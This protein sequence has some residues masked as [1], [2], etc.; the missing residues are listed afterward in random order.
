MLQDYLFRMPDLSGYKDAERI[1]PTAMILLMRLYFLSDKGTH[2]CYFSLSWGA[3]HSMGSRASLTRASTLLVDLGIVTCEEAPG[4]VNVYSFSAEF[5]K[6]IQTGNDDLNQNDEGTCLKMRRVAPQEGQNNLPQNDEGTCLKMRRGVA[7][8]EEGGCSKCGTI[9]RNEED[10]KGSQYRHAGRIRVN[11]KIDGEQIIIPLPAKP[12]KEEKGSFLVSVNPTQALPVPAL[13]SVPAQ[14]PEPAVPPEPTVQEVQTA[15]ASYAAS[16]T[17]QPEL[18]LVD[19]QL[20]GHK[21]MSYYRAKGWPRDMQRAV[22][23]W[24]HQI[25]KYDLP[26]LR[27][28]NPLTR[29]RRWNEPLT[30]ERSKL[31]GM[32]A[33]LQTAQELGIDMTGLSQKEP[34]PE[35]LTNKKGVIDV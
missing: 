29:P 28:E 21:F 32:K 33:M 35:H 6:S 30:A 26:R 24:V 12:A 18:A 13:P 3:R 15:L 10:L 2:P 7:Q 9:N 1:T 34:A 23:V 5:L 20:E 14:A 16:L 22:Q 27:N 19:W 25:I 11:S 4:K 31:S 17:S 8:N